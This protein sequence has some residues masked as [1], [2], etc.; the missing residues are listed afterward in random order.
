VGGTQLG[1]L[2]ACGANMPGDSCGVIAPQ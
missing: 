2:A 1:N